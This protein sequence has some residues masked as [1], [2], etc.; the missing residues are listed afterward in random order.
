[1]AGRGAVNGTFKVSMRMEDWTRL[2]RDALWALE[3]CS[4]EEVFL[5]LVQ[6]FNLRKSER[7]RI[8][9][10]TLTDDDFIT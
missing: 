9:L 5:Y 1:M 3:K 7:K 4:E 6:N 10:Y 8:E 2:D